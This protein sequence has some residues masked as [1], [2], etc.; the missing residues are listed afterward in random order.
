[1]M[2]ACFRL[3]YGWAV[4]I[5][6]DLL[7]LSERSLLGRLLLMSLL[8]NNFTTLIVDI[9]R[10]GTTIMRG[11]RVRVV[12]LLGLGGVHLLEATTHVMLLVSILGLTAI[13][14]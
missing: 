6:S 5:L 11:P 7:T 3:R 8:G 12:V 14:A 9:F 4:N 1:M 13:L 10:G 2:L